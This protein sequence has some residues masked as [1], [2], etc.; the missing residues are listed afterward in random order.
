MAPLLREKTA[1]VVKD[2]T[3]SLFDR[4]SVGFDAGL[5]FGTVVHG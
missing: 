4:V 2:A 1:K 5:S 3:L